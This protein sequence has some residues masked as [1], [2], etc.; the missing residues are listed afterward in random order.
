M[1]Q[2]PD[3]KAAEGLMNQPGEPIFWRG[4]LIA[5]NFDAVVGNPDKTNATH[6]P[7]STLTEVK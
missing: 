2:D 6:E 3:G 7:V 5:A 1:R 4:W